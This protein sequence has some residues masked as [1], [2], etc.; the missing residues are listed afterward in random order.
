M[1][2]AKNFEIIAW[3]SNQD[4]YAKELAAEVEAQLAPFKFDHVLSLE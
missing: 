3:T 4:D 1:E 2:A